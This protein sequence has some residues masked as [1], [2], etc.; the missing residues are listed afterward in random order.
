MPKEEILIHLADEKTHD[1]H[2]RLQAREGAGAP[3]GDR[4]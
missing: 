4:A 3:G 2:A 1:L